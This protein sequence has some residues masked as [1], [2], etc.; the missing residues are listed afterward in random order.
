MFAQD[1][2]APRTQEIEKMRRTN[3]YM[4][5]EN[6]RS[7]WVRAR[8]VEL[9]CKLRSARA[10]HDRFRELE[11]M[12]SGGVNLARKLLDEKDVAKQVKN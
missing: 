1:T 8:D 12:G 11:K 7:R 9:S 5:I 6:E 4:G 2:A 3:N 10:A